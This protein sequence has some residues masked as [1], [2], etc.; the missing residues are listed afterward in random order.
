[1]GKGP[2]ID[3]QCQICLK[4]GHSAKECQYR[5]DDNPN[6]TPQVNFAQPSSSPTAD[7]FLDS[8]AS[9]H[10]TPD[11]NCLTNYQPHQGNTVVHIGNGH[12]L[13]I[14]HTGSSYL[15]SKT[16]RLILDGVLH[17]PQMRKMLISISK[18]T[19]DNDIIVEFNNTGC[20]LKDRKTQE[21]L[22]EGGIS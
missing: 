16:K 3:V 13:T 20:V 1:M 6:T 9:S 18:L 22:L 15:E 21:V 8:G 10:I 12:G 4:I 2:N 11:L 19:Q 17:V 5:Y 7:W 14:S